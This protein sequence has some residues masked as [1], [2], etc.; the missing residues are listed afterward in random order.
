M[1]R[2]FYLIPA[3]SLVF[4]VSLILLISVCYT[5]IFFG[6][7]K[8]APSAS[9]Y[10]STSCGPSANQISI[11][12]HE[13]SGSTAIN[14]VQSDLNYSTSQFSIVSSTIAPG[15][16]L[17]QNDT[18]TPGSILIGVFP[19]PAGSYLS[20]DQV[21]AT[22][23]LQ[24]KTS[25]GLANA[26]FANSSMVAVDGTNILTSAT[27][28]TYP[29]NM[30]VNC[31][32]VMDTPVPHPSGTL[33]ALNGR[34]YQ[35]STD[36]NGIEVRSLITTGDVFTSY[37]Y[38]WFLVKTGTNGDSNLPAGPLMDTLAPG[39]I[40]AA[41]GTPVYIMTYESGNLVKQQISLSAFNAL[42]YSWGE[43]QMVAASSVPAATAST[44]LFAAQHPA[45]TLVSGG[46][47]T[48]LLD[49]SAK[50]W[51]FGPDAFVTN[52]YI[53]GKV[54]TATS[55]D[56][57]LPDGANVYMRQGNLLL[58]GGGIFVVDYDGSG[59]L[60]RPLGP[61]ECFANRWHYALRDLYQPIGAVPSRN[62]AIATC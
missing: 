50:R 13:N 58:T 47:K 55:A 39:T 3:K 25:T 2:I 10:L 52:N 5:L 46:G 8:A 14:G 15:W 18:S 49:Q 41:S 53:W 56:M 57:S 1:P 19:T 27:N 31:G 45:G 20:G 43:I 23:V 61:W 60:K 24:A 29:L 62:G 9:L 38:P 42:G 34:V 51:I 26:V 48:Y 54:K 40:F 30:I 4:K 59:I 36:A 28:S 12:I 35:L 17:A 37:G 11:N 7:S 33:V 21:V 16:T 6:I 22:V 44:V 32:S